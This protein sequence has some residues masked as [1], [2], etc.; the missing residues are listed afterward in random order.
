M[1]T[2]IKKKRKKKPLLIS[3]LEKGKALQHF[4]TNNSWIKLD[5]IK[6]TYTKVVLIEGVRSI[7]KGIL[8]D[9]LIFNV[10]WNQIGISKSEFDK[11]FDNNI[12]KIMK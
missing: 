6:E 2:L 7:E 8:G 12:T 10:T 5:F 4:K 9:N 11:V 3:Y 1:D